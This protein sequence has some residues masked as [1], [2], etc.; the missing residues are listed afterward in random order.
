MQVQYTETNRKV[1]HNGITHNVNIKYFDREKTLDL[2]IKVGSH[3]EKELIFPKCPDVDQA[4][5]KRAV[6]RTLSGHFS[7][8]DGK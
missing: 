5:V 7:K 6:A 8:P 2:L 3:R 4:Q 1:T